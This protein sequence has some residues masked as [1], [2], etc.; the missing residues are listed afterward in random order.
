[1]D[2]VDT[3]G[4]VHVRVQPRH[5]NAPAAHHTYTRPYVAPQVRV[6]HRPHAAVWVPGYWTH[7]GAAR[8]WVAGTWGYPPYAGWHWVAPHWAWNGYT[9]VWESG[10]WVPA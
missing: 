7:Y 3:A 2:T 6:V 8:T 1:M 5:H 9:W 4:H 10:R